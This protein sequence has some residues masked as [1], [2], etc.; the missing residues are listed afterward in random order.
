MNFSKFIRVAIRKLSDLHTELLCS[1]NSDF[2]IEVQQ[3]IVRLKHI[4]EQLILSEGE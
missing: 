4:Q 1:G 2:L 3:M